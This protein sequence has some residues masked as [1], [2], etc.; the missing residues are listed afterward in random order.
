MPARDEALAIILSI[1]VAL[2]MVIVAVIASASAGPQQSTQ[3]GPPDP[4]CVE[5]A[6]SCVVCSRTTEG[7]ACSTPG[8]ACT[9]GAPR[10]LRR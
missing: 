10:C 6:D 2:L 3:G 4:A 7:L 8:I 9:R 5:W 1:A